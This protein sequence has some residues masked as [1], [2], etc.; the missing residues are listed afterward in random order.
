MVS[1]T[2]PGQGVAAVGYIEPKGGTIKVSASSSLEGVRVEQVLV[3]LGDKVKAGQAIAILD[4]RDRLQVALE[5]AQR[6]VN[7]AEAKLAQIK[8]GAKP[9]EVQAQDAALQKMQ[10]ELAGQI[11]SQKAIIKELEA[12]LEG[13]QKSKRATITRI[14][15]EL[16]DAQKQCQRYQTLFKDGAVSE[17]QVEE[18]CLQQD[19]KTENL[20][21]AEVALRQTVNTLNAQITEAKATLDRIY[22]TLKQQVEAEGATLSAISEVRSVDIG[23]AQAELEKAKTLVN[24]AK[25][26]LKLA[27]IRAP[28]DGQILQIYTKP[29]EVINNEGMVNLGYTDQMYVRAEVYETDINRVKIGQKATISASEIAEDLEG[30]VEEIGLEIGRRDIFDT[31]PVAQADARVVQ[32]NLKLSPEASKKVAKLTNLQVNAIIDT[33]SL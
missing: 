24:K 31:D 20:R 15:A 32:V 1:Q 3:K 30:T 21:E 29:G 12:R 5:Q 7:L 8:A 4:S 16:R 22:T 11:A 2:A 23:V 26:E 28:R 13:E 6:E 25:A 27:Y 19:T 10:A 18:S 14:Q 33:S 9:G 17:Q